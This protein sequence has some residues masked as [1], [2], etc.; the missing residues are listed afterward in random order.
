VTDGRLN[1]VSL[2]RQFVQQHAWSCAVPLAERAVHSG[3]APRALEATSLLQ[4]TPAGA[5]AGPTVTVAVRS[6]T[7]ASRLRPCLDSLIA[8]DYPQVDLALIDASDDRRAVEA[9]IRDHFPRVRYVSSPG[10]GV[11]TRRA[12]EECRGDILALTDG[13]AIVDARWVT[14]LVNVFL[15]DP[16]VMTVSGLVLPRLL[17]PPF[18]PTLPGGAP[19]VRAWSRARESWDSV[20]D[21]PERVLERASANIAYWRPGSP[22]GSRYTRV[23]EPS[24]IVRTTTA[25]PGPRDVGLRGPVR[26]A[27]RAVDLADGLSAIAD[28]T[29]SDSLRL[30]VSW[31]GEMLGQ[32]RIHHRGAVVS[33]L[34]M[35]DVI[36]QR[37]TSAVLDAGLGLG[38][39]VARALLTADVTR[40]VLSRWEADRSHPVAGASRRTAA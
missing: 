13:E 10:P 5:A 14:A 6:R 16:E 40:F 2:V 1:E 28:V 18:R 33:P 25:S 9:L 38:P 4:A 32:V 19:F 17:R 35:G 26:E 39:Q 12:V 34:W 29:T 15:A 22:A 7:P 37:L 27:E 21:A 24:A 30:R 36:A 8:L 31:G 23:W 20:D 3:R 11:S